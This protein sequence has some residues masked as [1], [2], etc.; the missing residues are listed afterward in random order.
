MIT[1]VACPC[2]GEE[3]YATEHIQGPYFGQV[4]G[5]KLQQDAKGAFMVCSHCKSRVDLVGTGGQ[6]QLSPLQPCTRPGG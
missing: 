2:C 6:M 4:G 5:S 1:S 3:L